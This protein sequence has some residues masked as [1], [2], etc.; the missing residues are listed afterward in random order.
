MSPVMLLVAAWLLVVGYGLVYIGY[1]NLNGKS[2]SFF[3]AFGL[4]NFGGI[5]PPASGGASATGSQVGIPKSTSGIPSVLNP[6]AIGAAIAAAVG[7]ATGQTPS[8][9]PSPSRLG[10]PQQ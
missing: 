4:S 2:V 9:T 1:S 7:K 5:A 3:D 8:P 10:G 6:G